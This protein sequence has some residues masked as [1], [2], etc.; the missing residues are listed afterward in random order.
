MA[1]EAWLPFAL[2]DLGRFDEAIAEFREANQRFK[3]QFGPPCDSDPRLDAAVRETELMARAAERLPAVL[4][5]R[6]RPVDGTECLVF[7]QMCQLPCCKQYAAAGRFFDDAFAQQPDLAEDLKQRHRYNAARFAARVGCS[8][9]ADAAGLDDNERARLRRR[10]LDWLRADLKA[11]DGLLANAPDDLNSLNNVSAAM[12][13]WRM[14][15]DYTA[16]R[17]QCLGETRARYWCG[18]VSGIPCRRRMP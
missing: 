4:E 13:E 7:A 15:D 5:G 2:R 17:A 11:W 12:Q 1:V 6:D 18:G 8:Q 10:A 14:N 3:A 16:S 9:C